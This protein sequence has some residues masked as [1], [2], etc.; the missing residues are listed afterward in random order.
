MPRRRKQPETENGLDESLD[1]MEEDENGLSVHRLDATEGHNAAAR[2]STIR[3]ACETIAEL[4]RQIEG[5]KAER[6]A[7]IETR[8]VADLGMKKGHFAT[9]YKLYQMDH[10]DRDELQDTIRE[11]FSALGVGQ[12]LNW[13]DAVAGDVAA[14]ARG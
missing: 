5:I 6:K 12:Q 10:G 3:E 13:L 7:V 8:I 9:A 11:C 4:D 2:A 14:A 1:R